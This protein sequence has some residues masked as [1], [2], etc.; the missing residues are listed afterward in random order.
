MN[1]PGHFGDV[2]SDQPL[3]LLHVSFSSTR[4]VPPFDPG[5]LSLT[6]VRAALTVAQRPPLLNGILLLTMYRSVY[7]QFD[8]CAPP[9]LLESIEKNEWLIFA[10]VRMLGDQPTA[11]LR[12]RI[13]IPKEQSTILRALT[14]S[15]LAIR[16]F[17]SIAPERCARTSQPLSLPRRPE[18]RQYRA[19][20]TSES[21]FS[22]LTLPP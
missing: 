4:L 19:W 18:P 12:W 21:T 13:W 5:F 16:L 6:T 1:R 10:A 15:Y 20:N 14:D 3:H 8:S 7:Y 11:C 2:D 17:S 22:S 9:R